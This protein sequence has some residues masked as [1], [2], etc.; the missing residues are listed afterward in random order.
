MPDVA[1]P[2]QDP[3]TLPGPWNAV[4]AGY[5]EEFF[6]QLPVL[7]DDAI[8]TLSVP[9]SARVLDVATGPGT[10]AVRLAARVASV[11][12]VDFA[13][14]M[15]ERLRAHLAHDGVSNVE[16]LVMDGQALTFADETFDA[17]VS[18]FGVFL[19]ADRPRA[20]AEL[21]RVVRP[22]GRVLI[23][24][25]MPPD[26]NTLIGAGMSALRAALP[27]LPRPAG[28]L[29][30]QQPRVCEAELKAAGFRD[31]EARVVRLPV[32]YASVGAYFRTFE[33]AS[34]PFV[35][36]RK[37]LGDA[38]FAAATERCLAALRGRYGEGPL[39]L[40]CAAIFTCGVR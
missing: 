26:E 35:L 39:E 31:V 22:G 12:A 6:A 25:W 19:F 15:V 32:Q 23:T 24:S 40:E 8:M 33:R 13:E 4:A 1:A 28:P 7:V 27:E 11:A 16:A 20:L 9:P 17:A 37:K 14:S 18:M 34:A 5:D 38:A 2:P 30:T 10:V 36:L 3:M 29:P 21:R